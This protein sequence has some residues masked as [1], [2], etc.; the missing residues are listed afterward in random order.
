MLA[1]AGAAG[2]WGAITVSTT[3]DDASRCLELARRHENLWCTAGVHPLYSDRGP[4]DWNALLRVAEDPLC[5]AWGELGLDRYYSE[6]AEGVQRETL[7]GHLGAIVAADGG[8]G[9]AAG[10]PIVLHCREAFA[11][12][13]PEL[14]RA[15]IAGERCVFHCFTGGPADMEVVLGLGAW[16]SF[17][18]VLTYKNAA[19]VREA[20]SMA[21][22]DRVMVETDAPFLTPSPHRGVR[23]NEPKYVVHTASVLAEVFGA[24][25]GEFERTLDANAE[26]FFGVGRE[27]EKREARSEHPER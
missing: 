15:G 9:S 3:S 21:P 27:S 11:E 25:A 5:V 14:E 18:G 8:G 22:I 20:A 12:L 16:V 23:P 24:E 13:A 1:D 2:V 6:P 7:E 10:K 26:R 19:G 17:T 4:H